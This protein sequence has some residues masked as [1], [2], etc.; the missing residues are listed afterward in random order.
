M[1]NAEGIAVD[2]EHVYW[3]TNI[4][5][6]RANKDGTGI[7]LLV[8]EGDGGQPPGYGQVGSIGLDAT[9]VYWTVSG[10]PSTLGKAPK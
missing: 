2:A 4:G 10:E 1:S 6:F 3:G 5:L 7:A 8:R 9:C